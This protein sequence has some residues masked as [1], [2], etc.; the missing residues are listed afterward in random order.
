M[1][2]R[3]DD[4]VIVRYEDIN[5]FLYRIKT[6]DLY[7]KM[8]TFKHLLDFSKYQEEYFLHDKTN[9]KVPFTM[10]DEIQGKVLSEIVC[11]RS[12]LYSIQF[13]EGIT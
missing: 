7:S 3:F 4:T 6:E 12:K 11:L 10:T 8:A 13:E 1:K 5:S 2:P 9:K